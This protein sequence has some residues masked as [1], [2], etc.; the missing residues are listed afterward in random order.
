MDTETL[1]I[2]AGIHG[3]SI[4][5]RL[6]ESSRV[7]DPQEPLAQWRRYT[8][9][10]GMT[11]LRSPF[12]HHIG[13]SPNE[14]LTYDGRNKW[15]RNGNKPKRPRLEFFNI[16]AGN[17]A[18]KI[19]P[20]WEQAAATAIHPIPDGWRVET[21]NGDATARNLV[22]APGFAAKP[23]IPEWAQ[24]RDDA[25][26]V[27]SD[28]DIQALPVRGQRIAIVGGGITAGQVAL[29][30]YEKGANVILV[31]R[32]KLRQRDVDSDPC[33]LEPGCMEAFWQLP[34]Q[35]RVP[36]AQTERYSGSIPWDVYRPLTTLIRTG[37]IQHV[38]TKEEPNGKLA[39]KGNDV[40]IAI[41]ATGLTG[42]PGRQLTNQLE[43]EYGLQHI[44]GIPNTTECKWAPRLYVSGTLAQASLGPFAG[45][46]AGAMRA[47]EA[48]H[49]HIEGQSP[50]R[51]RLYS[52]YPSV[53]PRKPMPTI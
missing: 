9:N 50:S 21:T 51:R 49:E 48:I 1:I 10:T 32:H 47:G 23:L 27:F 43:D 8:G 14:L 19:R 2:G 46:I 33:Y 45:N 52:S 15:L 38:I 12:V 39:F 16:H 30:M 25:Y 42:A 18:R 40:D 35:F 28:T 4:A 6:G 11:A 5:H 24:G 36:L 17:I 7:I 20:R 3:T 53:R 22:L 41:L 34:P 26:H 29:S 31:S 44:Q 13:I 37:K